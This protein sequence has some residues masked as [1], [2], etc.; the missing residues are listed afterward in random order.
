MFIP[1]SDS[2]G[3]LRILVEMKNMNLKSVYLPFIGLIQTQVLHIKNLW[4]CHGCDFG[5]VNPRNL[6]FSSCGIQL[7]K[8][9]SLIWD[10]GTPNSLDYSFKFDHFPFLGNG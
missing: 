4:P 10:E 1:D 6:V 9:V 2:M 3:I 5:F 7:G 8:G